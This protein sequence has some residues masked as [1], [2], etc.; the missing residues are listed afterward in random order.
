MRGDFMKIALMIVSA[1]LM[2]N[3][4]AADAVPPA[5]G[6]TQSTY[7]AEVAPANDSATSTD[8]ISTNQ[9]STVRSA[10]SK[11]KIIHAKCTDQ[12]GRVYSSV[13]AGYAACKNQTL[14]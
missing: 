13:E 8:T 9:S 12:A 4:F 6:S 1:F 5:T 11:K 7:G 10:P 14:K 2:T 3:A